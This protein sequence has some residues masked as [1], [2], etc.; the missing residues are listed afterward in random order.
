MLAPGAVRGNYG[1]PPHSQDMAGTGYTVHHTA[2]SDSCA[3]KK[4]RL[5]SNI[6]D[7]KLL[8]VVKEHMIQKFISGDIRVPAET[9]TRLD[10][11]K[12]FYSKL[13][14]MTIA[15]EVSQLLAPAPGRNSKQ[16]RERFVNN[17]AQ[18]KSQVALKVVP[19]KERDPARP[20]LGVQ[21]AVFE[22]EHTGDSPSPSSAPEEVSAVSSSTW[23]QEEDEQLL[24]LQTEHGN[25]WAIVAKCLA[26]KTDSQVKNRWYSLQRKAARQQCTIPQV[27]ELAAY[28]L[29]N[30]DAARL[31]ARQASMAAAAA[32]AAAQM[33]AG[34]GG[35][36]MHTPAAT[37]APAATAVHMFG[38]G[39]SA[40]VGSAPSQ[41]ATL[42]TA[43]SVAPVHALPLPLP[44]QQTPQ[45]GPM[46]PVG[47]ASPAHHVALHRALPQDPHPSHARHAAASPYQGGS[48]YSPGAEDMPCATGHT[49]PRE[50]TSSSGGGSPADAPASIMPPFSREPESMA[51]PRRR[52][53]D[54]EAEGASG[55]MALA[56]GEVEYAGSRSSAAAQR[57]MA[58]RHAQ[59]LAAAT[60]GPTVTPAHSARGSIASNEHTVFSSGSGSTGNPKGSSVTEQPTRQASSVPDSVFSSQPSSSLGTAAVSGVAVSA[61]RQPSVGGSTF[62]SSF[63][64]GSARGSSGKPRLP[65]IVLDGGSSGRPRLDHEG[66][67]GAPDT[68]RQSPN[69]LS[70]R[71]GSDEARTASYNGGGVHL[72]A[73]DGGRAGTFGM[74]GDTDVSLTGGANP[75]GGGSLPSGR[76]DSD[77]VLRGAS[78]RRP[79]PLVRQRPPGAEGGSSARVALHAAR[80]AAGTHPAPAS[81]CVAVPTLD[82]ESAASSGPA[83]VPVSTSPPQGSASAQVLQPSGLAGQLRMAVPLGSTGTQPRTPRNRTHLQPMTG[84][85]PTP[86]SSSSSGTRNSRG[87]GSSSVSSDSG[88][89]LGAAAAAGGGSGGA[90]DPLQPQRISALGA[91][92][93]K[94]NMVLGGSN[95]SSR[96]SS[97]DGGYMQ[98]RA[99]AGDAP[100]P[101]Q[102]GSSSSPGSAG[103]VYR[104]ASGEGRLVG[105]MQDAN[106]TSHLRVRGERMQRDAK[107]KPSRGG[108]GGSKPS[109]RKGGAVRMGASS[110]K[111]Q[112]AWGS[113]STHGSTA[114]EVHL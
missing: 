40:S 93:L 66:S 38:A 76:S 62:G 1:Q 65:S 8:E 31:R 97:S 4:K 22:P 72:G 10:A 53:Q 43:G 99:S 37:A 85:L 20:N 56:R 79:S 35:V 113:N 41:D 27:V 7:L 11:E 44:L 90:L 101:N 51:P 80:E 60:D 46:S 17:L 9:V 26:H 89:L 77:T 71:A 96:M 95:G 69:P 55:L 47:T 29:R 111:P 15:K 19:L 39:A 100:P 50:H 42:S 105:G 108:R 30:T 63:Q 86:K 36:G 92:L 88:S 45:L 64:L 73:L 94:K 75:W 78:G 3:G 103:H 61:A 24:K 87:M 33:Q 114:S 83:A 16:C 82:V 98:H 109:V 13:Q 5:W 106:R 59:L 107:R 6:E 68:A 18:N 54:M 34:A 2:L 49:S 48:S 28:K 102:G 23:S 110:V 25:K 58:Q 70:S 67:S 81:P 14:W 52:A 112:R 84:T 91:P 21:V 57:A 32:A 74:D 12:S 104:H